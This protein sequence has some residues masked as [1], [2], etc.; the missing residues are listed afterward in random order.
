M[1]SSFNHV[2]FM[3]YNSAETTEFY[4]KVMGLRLVQTFVNDL[5]PSTREYN[6]HC[7]IFF[8]LD[9]GSCIAFFEAPLL[10]DVKVDERI[11]S[12]IQHVAIQLNSV[13]DF[14]R[15]RARLDEHGVEY[16][17][18]MIHKEG[19]RSLYFFD[20][21]GLRIEFIYPSAVNPT[22]G[23]PRQLV[24]DWMK[25]RDSIVDSNRT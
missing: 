3:C 20:P 18:P 16:L 6:P 24:D 8:E 22:E 4:T 11:G 19:Q 9:D 23:D 2:A 7:H 5:V 25:R 15:A 14:E 21:N 1:L 12:W 10:R 17:G 13:E